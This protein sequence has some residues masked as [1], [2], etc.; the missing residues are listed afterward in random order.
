MVVPLVG[1][2]SGGSTLS[3]DGPS[4]V[5]VE[6]GGG[7]ETVRPGERVRQPEPHRPC[8]GDYEEQLVLTLEHRCQHH[9]NRS[10]QSHRGCCFL[11]GEC[12]IPC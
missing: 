9:R 1:Q 7:A 4:L 11:Q 5:L 6:F 8:I 10:G 12:S 3:G 2:S